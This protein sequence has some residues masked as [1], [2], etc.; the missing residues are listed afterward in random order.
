[1]DILNWVYLLKNKLVKTKVQDP[2]KDLVILGNNVSYV[3]RGDKYQ[4]YGMTVEDFATYINESVAGNCPIQMNFKPGSIGEKVS[5]RKESSSDPNTHKDIII[6]GLLEITRGNN[7][8][9]IYNI[10][11]EGNYNPSNNS[12]ENTFWNTGYV[13]TNDIT[14]APLWDVQNRTYTDWRNAVQQPSGGYIPP[15]Y[16]GIPSVMK[17]DDGNIVKYYLIMFTEW[18]VGNNN[19]YGFAY[20]RYEILSDVFFEQPSANNTN[21]PN[22][23]DI[24]SD[25]VHLTRGYTGGGLYNTVSEPYYNYASPENTRWNSSFT[26]S[27]SGYSGFDDLSNL[28]SR[29]YSS[30][31]SALDGSIGNNLPGTDLI[32]HDL[33]TDLYYK[34]VFDSWA[35]GCSNAGVG[36]FTGTSVVNPGSGYPASTGF[37]INVTGGTGING[38]MYLVTDGSGIPT[39]NSI[40][41]GNDYTVGDILTINYPGVTD[42]MTIEVTAVCSMGGF[43]YTRTVIPQSCGVKFADGT[44][45]NT[46]VTAGGGAVGTEMNYVQGSLEPQVESDF[47]QVSDTITVAPVN[48]LLNNFTNQ[49]ASGSWILGTYTNVPITGG[50]GYGATANMTIYSL[51][52]YSFGVSNPGLNYVPGDNLSIYAGDTLVTFTV[53]TV[54][55]IP[56]ITNTVYKLGGIANFQE[57]GTNSYSYLIGVIAGDS[58]LKLISDSTTISAPV[59]VFDNVSGKFGVNAYVRDDLGNATPL[60]SALIVLD[61][62]IASPNEYF[63]SIVAIAS[64][65]WTGTAYIDMEFMSDQALTYYN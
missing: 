13:N 6:P 42:L 35:R 49:V 10:A 60:T 51:G 23:I 63:V 48:G 61:N 47:I 26:D 31:E 2:K 34:V 53:D 46:A 38:Q 40:S 9:G 56:A 33:T 28:E 50:S 62:S 3:K 58:D 54:T 57:T 24:I 37:W 64:P 18:G 5:F 12:P 22:V 59:N 27:R 11:V 39:I 55:N 7:G 4:S 52:G 21:T 19:E 15:M 36:G 65:D 1:M 32:M 20:D 44:I 41:G 30:F 17:Y 25:G 43:G 29:I 8:G 45:M 16:V 14:W